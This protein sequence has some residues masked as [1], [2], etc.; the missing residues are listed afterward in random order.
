MA[1]SGSLAAGESEYSAK[2]YVSAP[3]SGII[4]G[5]MGVGSRRKEE[6]KWTGEVG[7]RRLLPYPKPL[8]RLG[9]LTCALLNL[10][11]R[12][13]W[14]N[15]RSPIGKAGALYKVRVQMSLYPEYTSSLFLTAMWPAASVLFRIGL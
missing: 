8:S 14:C 12:Y 6:Q 3:P 4:F 1:A 10:N 2:W 7:V 11:Q 9:S 13:C 5:G 15:P